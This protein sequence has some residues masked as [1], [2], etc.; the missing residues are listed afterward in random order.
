MNGGTLHE[1]TGM[2]WRTWVIALGALSVTAQLYLVWGFDFFPTVDGP[3]HVHLAHAMYEA[4]RGDDFYGSL[5]ELNSRFN[6]NLATQGMLVALMAIAPPAIAEKLWLTLY[7]TSYAC[8]AAYALSSINRKSLCLLPLLVLCSFSFPLVFGFY[9]FAFSTVV[10]LAWLGFWW[11]HRHAFDL[12]TILGHLLFSS[13]AYATH[14]FAFVV[15]VLAIAVAGLAT[16]VAE[17]DQPV[18]N[19]TG[20]LSPR[21]RSLL[22]HA[23]P[24]FIGS[25]P[26]LAASLYF[27]LG[28]FAE[29]TSA[30]AAAMGGDIVVPRIQQF[31]AATSLAPYED[32]EFAFAAVITPLAFAAAIVLFLKSRDRR[33]TAAFGMLFAAF[34]ALYVAMPQQW[35]VRW[36]PPRFQPIA[37]IALL[38]WLAALIPASIKPAHWKVMGIAGLALVLFS[39]SIRIPIFTRLDSLYQELA[40]TAPHIKENSSLVL[41]R[42]HSS[43]ARMD[44][45][46]QSGSRIADSRHSIDLKN[47]Q[48]Q[49][50]DHPIQFRPGIGAAAALGGDAAIVSL[51]PNIRLMAYE[52]QTGRPI[53]YVLVYGFRQ[54][55]MNSRGLAAVDRQLKA[56]YQLVATSN[57]LGFARLYERTRKP[58]SINRE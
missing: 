23:A 53:D 11:R 13:A 40:S 49:A 34:L 35:L 24:P 30:G 55:A 15:S 25:I 38:L 20:S 4:L 26:A 3:A 50:E 2:A 9:N 46:I 33:R 51:S 39:L 12:P 14:I 1:Q 10:F 5:V 47:F 29:K 37:L 58:V 18:P 6:P 8:A 52:Q 28:R 56:D 48:G 7:F 19:T 31:L 42:L 54:F 57:P 21:W 17:P 16:V 32:A 45:L 43:P 41:L 44:V 27:L 22:T 36:M